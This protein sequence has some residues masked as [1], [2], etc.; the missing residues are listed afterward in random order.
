MDLLH[1]C[2]VVIFIVWSFITKS[3]TVIGDDSEYDYLDDDL[4]EN[5]KPAN[6]F[7]SDVLDGEQLN[8]SSDSSSVTVKVDRRNCSTEAFIMDK[9]LNGTGY[10]KYRLPCK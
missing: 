2:I 7:W 3:M 1:R 6:V 5:P 10:N 9:L 8:E 4:D